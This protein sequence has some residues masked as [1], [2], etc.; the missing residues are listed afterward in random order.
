[1]QHVS[2]GDIQLVLVSHYQYCMELESWCPHEHSKGYKLDDGLV[3]TNADQSVNLT[4][5]IKCHEYPPK[6]QCLCPL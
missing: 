1:M 6:Q 2:R 4:L 3:S 5:P